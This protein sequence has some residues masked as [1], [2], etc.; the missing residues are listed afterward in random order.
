MGYVY[1]LLIALLHAQQPCSMICAFSRNQHDLLQESCKPTR[2]HTWLVPLSVFDLEEVLE[3]F[4]SLLRGGKPPEPSPAALWGNAGLL[5]LLLSS[6]AAE[7]PAV[8]LALSLDAAL[9]S[10]SVAGAGLV[11]A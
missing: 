4:S 9:A 11:L 3:V 6:D 7:V 1:F 5:P 8:G 2:L 10:W